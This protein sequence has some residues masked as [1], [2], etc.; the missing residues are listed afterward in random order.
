MRI[1]RLHQ[2]GKLNDQHTR[3]R[4]AEVMR[5][6]SNLL[7][8]RVFGVE[9]SQ[10][11]R[12]KIG[13]ILAN[14]L[15]DTAKITV[16]R[17]MIQ[18]DGSFEYTPTFQH[19]K[20]YR[21]EKVSEPAFTHCIDQHIKSKFK[22]QGFIRFHH[23]LLSLLMSRDAE[24]TAPPRLMPMVV[25]PKPWMMCESGGYLTESSAQPLVRVN[26]N[27]VLKEM[28]QVA[29][30]R[31]DLETVFHGLDILGATPWRVNKEMLEIILECWQSEKEWPS[32]PENAIVEP[33]PK[34]VGKKDAAY[35]V[36]YYAEKKRLEN[37]E[38]KRY[39]MRCD[40]N[41]K[42]LLAKSVCIQQLT[43]S[44]KTKQS[45]FPIL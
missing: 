15:I 32:I 41:Y 11:M 21:T 39:S 16:N 12:A 42:I 40:A 33:I 1:Y 31:G 45:T 19:T 35:F 20:N 29:D 8:E 26:G 23:E 4:A 10:A 14:L 9:W 34:P 6:N 38:K 3:R 27:F 37:A 36:K 13:A 2:D 5:K 7:R 44:L 17:K 22:V 25:P 30:A 24:F 18:P 43:S 28:L